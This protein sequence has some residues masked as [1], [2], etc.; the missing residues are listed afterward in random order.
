M[1]KEL[2]IAGSHSLQDGDYVYLDFGVKKPWYKRLF[3]FL[4]FRRF[5]RFTVTN[6]TATTFTVK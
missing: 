5:Q 1:K 2:T 3:H 4:T 6:T